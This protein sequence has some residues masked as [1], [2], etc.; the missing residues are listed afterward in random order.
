MVGHTERAAKLFCSSDMPKATLGAQGKQ[1]SAYSA[2][3]ENARFTGEL[4]LPRSP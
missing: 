1:A 3:L 4:L 2:A